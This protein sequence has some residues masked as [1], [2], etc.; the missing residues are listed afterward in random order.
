MRPAREEPMAMRELRFAPGAGE[1]LH[2]LHVQVNE[3]RA[4]TRDRRDARARRRPRA[5]AAAARGTRELT[6]LEQ[7]IY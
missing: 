7:R 4:G 1:G 3:P 2:R 5:G 6:Q